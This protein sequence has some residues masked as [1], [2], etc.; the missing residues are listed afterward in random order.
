[1]KVKDHLYMYVKEKG[2]HILIHTTVSKHP[3]LSF[4]VREVPEHNRLAENKSKT[5]VLYYHFASDFSQT[6]VNV[7]HANSCSGRPVAFSL[8]IKKMQR[9]MQRRVCFKNMN[10]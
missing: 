5:R 7:S 1:M 4:A 9:K 6:L 10:I 8:H 3:S 2:S